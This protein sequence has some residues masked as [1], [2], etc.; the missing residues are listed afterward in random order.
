MYSLSLPL[1][2]GEACRLDPIRPDETSLEARPHLRRRFLGGDLHQDVIGQSLEKLCPRRLVLHSVHLAIIWW[3]HG[4]PETLRVEDR[5][6]LDR[7]RRVVRRR[8]HRV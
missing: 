2:R 5:L 6:H 1:E 4:L 3:R 7:P 8:Q